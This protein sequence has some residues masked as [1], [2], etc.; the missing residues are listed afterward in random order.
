[1]LHAIN[2]LDM[3]I[4]SCV[5]HG[6]DSQK[7]V[8]ALCKKYSAVRKDGNIYILFLWGEENHRII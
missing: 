1:M 4:P 3:I 6:K 8:Q 2:N 7:R 5:L